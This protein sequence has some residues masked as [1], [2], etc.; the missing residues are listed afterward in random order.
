M[1][2]IIQALQNQ[3]WIETPQTAAAEGSAYQVRK[4]FPVQAAP[5]QTA[6][7]KPSIRVQAAQPT[8]ASVRGLIPYLS[9]LMPPRVTLNPASVE[10]VAACEYT[11]LCRFVTINQADPVLPV[12]GLTWPAVFWTNTNAKFVK[13]RKGF[14]IDFQILTYVMQNRD[15]LE[16]LH[17]ARDFAGA[18]NRILD[19]CQSMP[20][21]RISNAEYEFIAQHLI[22]ALRSPED[23]S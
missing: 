12:I 11:Y 3:T 10:I 15:R 5:V 20:Q 9:R 14:V 8:A 23:Y 6:V 16:P 4:I 22:Q 13:M 7:L 2:T 19:L 18:T 1:G 17:F 21:E